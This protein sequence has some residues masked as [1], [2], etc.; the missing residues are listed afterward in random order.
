MKFIDFDF[1]YS[2]EFIR[3]S[4]SNKKNIESKVIPKNILEYIKKN[5]L[6]IS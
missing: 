1:P 2:S 3:K 4:I 5:S 6:Y